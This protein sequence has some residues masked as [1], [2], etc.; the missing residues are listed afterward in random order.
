MHYLEAEL[1][2]RIRSDSEIWRFVRAGSLDG[3]WYWDLENPE[4]QYISPEFWQLLGFDPAEN[5]HLPKQWQDLIFPEDIEINKENIAKQIADPN[6]PYDQTVRCKA[7]DGETVWVRCRG[8]AIRDK[9]GK[10]IRMLGTHTDV[11]EV[12][13]ERGKATQ[14]RNALETTFNA[15]ASGIIAFDAAGQIVQCNN[16]A[17]HMLGGISTLPPFDWPK[18]ISFLEPE[19]MHPL[20]ANADPIHRALSGQQLVHEL[21]LIRRAGETSEPRYVHVASTPVNAPDGGVHSVLILDDVSR[22]ERNRQVV[23]R[24]GRL[25]ALGQLTGGIAHD[26]N[27][28]L[29]SLLYSIVMAG[30]TDNPQRRT[31]NLQE[32]E[33]S[34][35]LARSLTARLMAFARKQPGLSDVQTIGTLLSGFQRL[36]RPMLD[37]NISIILDLEDPDMIVF[38]ELSQLESALMNLVLNSRDAILRSGRG[39][40]ITLSARAVEDMQVPGH[41]KTSRFVEISVTDDGPGMSAEVLARATDPFFT[42]KDSNSGTGLGLATVYGFA[43]QSNSDLRIYSEEGVGTTVQLRLPRGTQA[44]LRE[45]P[46]PSSELVLG[47]GETILLVEDEYH[48]LAATSKLLGD[49]GYEVITAASGKEA[50]D[51]TRAK[52]AYDILLTDVVMPGEIGGFDLARAVRELRP[53]IPIVYV[54]GYI[55]FTESEM[56]D[57]KAPL[58]QK[59]AVPA[60]LSCTLS[61]LLKGSTENGAHTDP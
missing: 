26:F 25:D 13:G 50:L 57:V 55:G 58:L 51:I 43:Q 47:Q 44:G 1:E 29:T 36:V 48:I 14:A 38:C 59:P 17:R 30:R 20:E 23:E 41:P 39:S 4:Q 35:E 18:S 45:D 8:L 42:T 28:I 53:D 19:G 12:Q 22:E 10:A 54:S 3:V 52:R 6:H 27:N 2:H 15:V 7:A 37:E 5:E 49:I 34:I 16:V 40:T 56:G 60:E 24:K 31:E 21:H 33:A 46:M 32:A 9:A 11:T 61:R